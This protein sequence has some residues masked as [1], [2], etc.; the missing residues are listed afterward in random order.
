LRLPFGREAQS[1]FCR[2][3]VNTKPFGEISLRAVYTSLNSRHQKKEF[4]M[5]S[6][7]PRTAQDSKAIRDDLRALRQT[8]GRNIHAARLAGRVPLRQLAQVTGIGEDLLDRY[9]LGRNDLTFEHLARIAAG[10]GVGA[11]IL[12]AKTPAAAPDGF[13]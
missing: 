7:S 11:E 9:E 2:E 13:L 10:L 8:I 6:K 5:P 3:W 12:L 4:S 1:F